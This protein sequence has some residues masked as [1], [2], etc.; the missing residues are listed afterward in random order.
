MQ[1][2]WTLL[3]EVVFYLILPHREKAVYTLTMVLFIDWPLDAWNA[4]SYGKRSSNL[5]WAATHNMA[6]KNYVM[7]RNR[8]SK[9]VMRVQVAPEWTNCKRN[10]KH[11]F[12]FEWE[13]SHEVTQN[14]K[15]NNHIILVLFC[16][17]LCAVAHVDP[18]PHQAQGSCYSRWW[19]PPPEQETVL[20]S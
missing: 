2:A 10:V 18:C 17:L 1:K 16:I 3:T 14:K 12:N 6:A 9:A 20:S 5:D 13:S 7:G 15:K 19:P 11:I 4:G 8:L